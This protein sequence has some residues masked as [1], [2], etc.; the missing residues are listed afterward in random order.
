[1]APQGLMS[2]NSPM[3]I[4]GGATGLIFASCCC[5]SGFLPVF[6]SIFACFVISY[7]LH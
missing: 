2:L 7:I 1:M 3:Q 4:V 6:F 5:H